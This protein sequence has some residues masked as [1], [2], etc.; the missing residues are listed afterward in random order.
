M[1]QKVDI[2]KTRTRTAEMLADRSNRAIA[3]I[4]V[5]AHKQ[6]AGSPLSPQ[7]GALATTTYERHAP[8]TRTARPRTDR[9]PAARCRLAGAGL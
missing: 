9:P 8:D 5:A 3:L 2:G 4:P 7:Q 6:N 1:T